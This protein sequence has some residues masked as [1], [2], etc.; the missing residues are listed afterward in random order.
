[1]GT[2]T[3][4]LVIHEASDLVVKEYTCIIF[5]DVNGDGEIK[6]SD[7]VLIKNHIMG[8]RKLEENQ[9]LAADVKK[10]E[11]VKASDYVL[12]KNYIMKGNSIRTE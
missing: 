6:A 9:V 5:G 2:G 12:I 3:K 8:T 11:Q 10:D 4:I 7:Y 1:M